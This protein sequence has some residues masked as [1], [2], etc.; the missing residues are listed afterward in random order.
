MQ[1]SALQHIGVQDASPGDLAVFFHVVQRTGLDP[2]ARQ[3]YMIGRKTKDQR[4][5]E[6]TTKQTIQTGIDG[7]RLIGRRASARSGDSVSVAAPQ[8]CTRDGKWLDVWSGEWGTP[9]AARVTITRDGDPFTAVAMFDEYKQ[10]KRDGGLTQMWAQRPAGQIAKC[11]EAAAWRMAFPQDL[12][13]VYSDDELQHADSPP[14]QR[15]RRQS[16]ADVLGTSEADRPAEPEPSADAPSAQAVKALWATLN[17]AGISE[18]RDERLRWMSNHVGREVAT[19]KDLT[20]AEVS[21]LI[22]TA[23]ANAEYAAEVA[24][25]SEA[26]EQA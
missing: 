11:A 15:A 5:G 2:F 18:D 14:P 20:A 22:D 12:A 4:T 6:W 24:A 7:F 10:T 21:Q 3:I 1:V 8:W 26:G 23:K 25:T 13:G 17:E 19:S 16:A 9:L